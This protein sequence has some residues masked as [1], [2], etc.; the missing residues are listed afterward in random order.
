MRSTYRFRGVASAA[1]STPPLATAG[2]THAAL[3]VAAM[4]TAAMPV[5]NTEPLA[6][7]Q[8]RAQF[9]LPAGFAIELAAAEPKIQKPVNM[10]L[11]ARGRL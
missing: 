8:Q 2:A 4:A 9:K 11:D 7:E 5:V 1:F 10:A 6:P 3:V